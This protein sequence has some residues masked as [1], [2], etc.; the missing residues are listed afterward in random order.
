MKAILEFNLDNYDD[1]LSHRRCIDSLNM[2][3]CLNN[4]T[5]AIKK[6]VYR[7]LESDK[8]YTSE[9]MFNIIFDKIADELESKSINLNNLLY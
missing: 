9:E 6:D 4:I 1:E 2:A 7:L 3:F 8:I 5:G